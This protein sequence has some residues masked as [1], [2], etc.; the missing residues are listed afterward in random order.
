LTK[1]GID[2]LIVKRIGE[3]SFHTLKGH[4]IDIYNSKGDTVKEVIDNLLNGK[5]S[6]LVAPTH[7]SEKEE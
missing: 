4:F 7:S 5:L 1:Y 2:A 3:I 6:L